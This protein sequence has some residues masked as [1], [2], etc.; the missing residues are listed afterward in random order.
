VKDESRALFEA[1]KDEY[2]AEVQALYERA[3]VQS[4]L[5]QLAMHGGWFVSG[6]D[7]ETMKNIVFVALTEFFET[8]T[9]PDRTGMRYRSNPSGQGW[10]REE[11]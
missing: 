10:V 4:K 3:R 1:L 8:T 6:K 11:L 5:M 2:E 7:A 9:S